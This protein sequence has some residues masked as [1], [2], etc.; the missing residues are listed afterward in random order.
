MAHTAF[1]RTVAELRGTTDLIWVGCR[2]MLAEGACNTAECNYFD[3][4]Y[5]TLQQK[6]GPAI[7][8][9]SIAI[10]FFSD[11]IL[12]PQP[13]RNRGNPGAGTMTFRDTLTAKLASA[14]GI[15]DLIIAKE[16][17]FKTTEDVLRAEYEVIWGSKLLDAEFE[18][19]Y[20]QNV[21]EKQ[22]SALCLSGGGIRSAAFSLGVLQVLAYRGLL[23]QFQYLS[24]VS[25]G[26][27]IGGW[28]SR[29]IAEDPQ[30]NAANIENVLS[31]KV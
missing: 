6:R 9:T 21:Q 18:A 30:Q 4:S 14:G 11:L 31:R 17:T 16:N 28:L 13:P 15:K 1:R 27:Y 20:R 19:A 10:D 7:D 3:I 2:S 12:R 23:T 22:Q 8:R 29:W 5:R 26:G 24:T 25:G